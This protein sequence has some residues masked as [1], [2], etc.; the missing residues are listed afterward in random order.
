MNYW[1]I[2]KRITTFNVL[3][4]MTK[5]CRLFHSTESFNFFRV[6][7]HQIVKIFAKQKAAHHFWHKFQRVKSQLNQKTLQFVGSQVE[8]SMLLKIILN[9][10]FI[11]W[12]NT[13]KDEAMLFNYVLQC[14]SFGKCDP[15]KIH[16]AILKCS[17]TKPG[18]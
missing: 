11:E 2:R 9:G 15:L 10:K 14:N 6:L 12:L 16:F 18:G 3:I 5:L 4:Y 1:L 7:L 17:F 13:Y 8:C